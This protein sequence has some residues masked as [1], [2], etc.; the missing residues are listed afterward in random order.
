MFSIVENNIF[1]QGKRCFLPRKTLSNY[2]H[3]CLLL[4]SM[5]ERNCGLLSLITSDHPKN[6]PQFSVIS[7]KNNDFLGVCFTLFPH[8]SATC[9]PSATTSKCLYTGL[10][11]RL[12][13]EWQIKTRNCSR[14]REKKSSTSQP[15]SGSF[16]Y[17]CG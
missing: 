17:S 8:L 7:F 10:F 9:H 12:V 11:R 2:P 4:F 13:A 1:L 3:R 16:R 5:L 6:F 14:A 15:L